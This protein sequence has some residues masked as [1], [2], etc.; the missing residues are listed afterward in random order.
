MS[1]AAF[2]HLASFVPMRDDTGKRI[3]AVL[4]VLAVA[5]LLL[6]IVLLCRRHR[7]SM[8]KDALYNSGHIY[9]TDNVG[10]STAM[11]IAAKH[12]SADSWLRNRELHH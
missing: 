1:N 10:K 9:M 6:C 3:T 8:E 2:A 11:A 5:I 12:G 7:S 4:S